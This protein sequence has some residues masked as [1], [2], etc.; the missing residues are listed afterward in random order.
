MEGC[1]EEAKRW[2]AGGRAATA[3]KHG[4]NHR[5][6]FLKG[7]REEEKERRKGKLKKGGHP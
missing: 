1:H 4:I 5:E 3:K 6:E 2:A 7:A